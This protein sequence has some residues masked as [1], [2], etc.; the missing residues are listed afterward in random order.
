MAA[1]LASGLLLRL[2]IEYL[3]RPGFLGFPDTN[4]Y[5]AALNQRFV[6]VARPPGYPLFLELLWRP[7]G[8]L[9]LIVLV[10]HLL[11]LCT[12]LSAYVLARLLG[13]P[14]WASLFPAAVVAFGGAQILLEHA[15]LSE[16]PFA[17]LLVAAFTALA[18]GAGASGPRGR[19]RLAWIA[20]GGLLLGLATLMRTYA[21]LTLLPVLAFVLLA[22]R[23]PRRALTAAASLL[24]PPVVVVL[25]M[26]GW[27]AQ[28]GGS[29]ALVE[30]QFYNYYGRVATFA[31]CT[32]FT[33]PAPAEKL[34]VTTPVSQRAGQRYWDFD[35]ESP[36]LKNF[37]ASWGV[38]PDRKLKRAVRGFALAAVLNQPGDYLRTIA[39]DTWRIFNPGFPLNPNRAVG[40]SGAGP[41]P[42]EL[43]AEL[44]DRTWSDMAL[45]TIVGSRS[46][47]YGSYRSLN[48]FFAYESVARISDVRIALLFLLALLAPL[49]TN[50]AQRRGA[51]MLVGAALLLIMLPIFVNMYNYRYVVPVL[52]LVAVAAALGLA[53]TAERIRGLSAGLAG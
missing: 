22:D 14:R 15:Y 4:A 32:K 6:D 37:D 39:R 7:F 44:L 47:Q 8:D 24:L 2:W 11:G 25:A 33:P 27:H 9:E 43:R 10:Q 1:I 42:G 51:L 31:D 46:D 26:M 35:L 16:A 36:L 48:A 30:T 17:F 5:F 18:A 19:R 20:L 13:A 12:A 45:G 21:A 49:L 23:R 41:G 50:G 34:C 38:H 3:W 53:A 28:A 52:P 29:F 40:N